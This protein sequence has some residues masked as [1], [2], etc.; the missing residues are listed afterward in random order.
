MAGTCF[1]RHRS[2]LAWGLGLSIA[3]AV[4]WTGSGCQPTVPGSII[5]PNGPIQLSDITAILDDADLDEAARR[6][7]LRA[8]GITDELLIDVLIE[9]GSSL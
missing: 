9:D 4:V 5:G 2:W 6:E 7:A 3:L 8:L 1:R